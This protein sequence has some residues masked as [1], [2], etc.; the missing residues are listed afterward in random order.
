M[1][2][3]GSITQ[4]A[5]L[6][7]SSQPAVSHQLAALE[8][9]AGTP[10]LRREARGVRLTPAGR[11]ALGDARRAVDAVAA[12]L[13]SARAV[14]RA[15]GGSLRIA[16]AQSLITVLAPVLGAWR[17]EHDQVAITVRESTSADELQSL[18]DADDVDLVLA[19]APLPERFSVAS[20]ADEEIVLVAPVDHPL[21]AL[22]AVALQDIDG[23]RLVQFAPSN[24]LS[25]WLERSLAR[26]DVR[27]EP[28]IQTAVTSAAPQ[29]AAAGLGVAICPVSALMPGFH[30]AVR[31]FA[32][33]WTRPLVAATAGVPDPLAA[34]FIADLHS[35]GVPVPDEVRS[36]LVE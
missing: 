20:V 4:A 15:G 5:A 23:A 3:S 1:A 26:A 30:G 22:P 28:V 16:T 24:G 27:A 21:A 10:L 31:S 29:L 17:R 7:H 2:D 14:G 18:L 34:R 12:A 11:A 32:P 8:R 19:P 33:R 6:L 25:E 35:A 36:Q 13:R 9:E